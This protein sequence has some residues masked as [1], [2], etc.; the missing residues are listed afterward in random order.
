MKLTTGYRQEYI[1]PCPKVKSRQQC[2]QFKTNSPHAALRKR[3]GIDLQKEG[4]QGVQVGT[5]QL[6]SYKAEQGGD[7]E[8]SQEAPQRELHQD[9]AG[10]MLLS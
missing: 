9:W 1:N 10:H 4:G 2:L 3:I 7:D 8:G 6:A 5:C